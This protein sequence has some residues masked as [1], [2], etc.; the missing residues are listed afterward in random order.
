MPQ[1]LLAELTEPGFAAMRSDQEDSLW[2]G[3]TLCFIVALVTIIV[4][5]A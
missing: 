1:A 2:F 3:T 4:F 5:S